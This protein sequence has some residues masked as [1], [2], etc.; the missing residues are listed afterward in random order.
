MTEF[1]NLEIGFTVA[2]GLAFAA[3]LVF[4]SFLNVCRVRMAAGE[5]IAWPGSHCPRCGCALRWWQ[6]V[7]L[8]S[9][10]ALRGRCAGCREGISAL[11]PL[12]ELSIGLLWAGLAAGAITG[13]SEAAL[14]S[15]GQL[16]GAVGMAVF[17]WLLVLL[18]ALD[19]EHL[20]LP[21]AVTLPA[22]GLGLVYRLSLAWYAPQPVGPT[23]G[24][25]LRLAGLPDSPVAAV[26]LYGFA[27]L[28]GAGLVLTI[29]L[30]YWLV[31]R[32]E[33]MGLGDAKLMAALGA[34]LGPG[35][36]LDA[37]FAAVLAATLAAL[38]W[39]GWHRSSREKWAAMPLPL[40]TFLA[41]AA[42][43]E[44]FRPEWLWS[45]WSGLFLR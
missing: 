13:L 30:V 36:A 3:G 23:A 22:I 34:W 18:A 27:A 12:Y 19:A 16:M 40:G 2:I 38:V 4:G 37:F 28:A 42:L 25:L 45:A 41:V 43:L 11:Y 15:M 33:G 21:D 26:L 1:R 6:N 31:R 29:R 44:V 24:A 10:I 8:V 5:N 39:L 35:A 20:W 7:P 14:P 32:R 17:C 9:W